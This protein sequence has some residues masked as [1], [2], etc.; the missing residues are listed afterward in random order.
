MRTIAAILLAGAACITTPLAAQSK[1]RDTTNSESAWNVEAPKG[2]V[3]KQVPIRTDEGTWI[4][5]DVSP[6]GRTL[7]FTLLGDIYTMPI[8]GGTPRRI[9]DGL[10]WDVQPRFSPDGSRIAF[11][12]DRGGGDNIWVMNTD[13]TDK[14][15]VTKENFRLLNQPTWSPD[16]R[17][18]AAKKHYTTE[19]SAG[20]GEI[21]LYHVSG[22]G[23]V[24]VVERANERLQK[25][26]GEPVFAPDGSAIYYTRNT[27]PGNVFEYAQDSNAGIFAIER[28][29]LAT[30]EVTTA[31][32]GYGGAVRPAPSP[33]GA[34]LAFVRRDKDQSQLWVKDIENGRERMIFGQLDLDV[35]ETW[36][37]TGVYPN[38]DWLPDSSGIVFWAGGK[39]NRVNRDGT[40]HAVIPFAINDTRG[41][42][43]APHP[44]IAVAPDTFV[45]SMPRFATLSPDS[46]RVVFES[47]GRLYSKSARG[48]DAPAPL[49]GDTADVVEAFPAF[50]R[51]GQNLAYVRWSDNALG[52]IVIADANGQNRRVLTGPGHFGNLAFSPDGSM[53]AF[54]KREGGYLTAADYSEN[55]GIYVISVNG[56]EA[57]LVSRDGSVPQWGES[58]SRLFMVAREGNGIALISTDLSGEAKRIHAKGEL[59]NDLRISPDGR[60]I[61]FRQN[62]EVFAMPVIPGGKPVDVSETGGALPVTK[63]SKGGADYLGWA[64][65]GET[66]FWSIGPSLQSA[67]V[68]ELFPAAPKADG[69]KAASYTP[70]ATGITLGVTVQAAKPAGTTV[71]TGARVLTMKAGLGTQDAGVIENGLI[72]ITGD[73]ITGV[74]DATT[75]RIRLPDDAVMIDASGKTI[76]PGLVDAHAHGAYGVG[77][78][79]PQQN[80]ALLQDLALGVTTV[81]NPSSQASTVF[82]AAERQRAGLTLGPR[83]FSTGEIIYGAKAPGVYA[84][85][86]T[87]EDALAHVRRIKAQGGISVKNYNQPRREQRQMVARAAAAENML[88]VAEGGSLFGMDMNLVADGNSTLEHNVPVDVFYEDVLQFFGQSNSNYTPTLV[89]TYGGLAG[90]PYWRQATNV[91]ENPLMVHTPPKMLLAETGRRTTAPD[92][93]FVDDNNARE[94]RKLAERGVKV[95]IGAHGQQA[96]IGAHWELW[97]FVRGGMTPVEALKAGTIT[98]AQSLGM[99]KDIGSIEVGKLADLVI[100]SDDPSADIS[101]SDNIEKVMLGGRLYDAVTMN[102]VSTGNAT[103]QPYWWEANGGNGAG[104]G[105]HTTESGRGHADGDAG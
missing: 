100:L 38:I 73:R 95:S 90:D 27:T 33:D 82:A 89:V 97:S 104:G 13:G 14:R 49:T 31:V 57:R 74:Y 28:H 63:V 83:I 12:S 101:N 8:E 35:Q 71:I 84:R 96:G 59:A 17:F 58:A 47:L 36:A 70:P 45:T 76:M 24:Q 69:A 2:A 39:L 25:E 5:V 42:A 23:G 53:I 52:D 60:T 44:D 1:G 78:L 46:T 67:N 15:Q 37:V 16:G 22:G 10:A 9:A 34:Q 68:A 4:D 85:I 65:G 81:H 61:A 41:I 72:V 91:W 54:E 3:I 19:R 103:R 77:D 56:G 21:W 92:W 62:Y 40:G 105:E 29:D 75:V 102:E 80:W 99:G 86:D 32:S 87:Y 51:D 88:V 26:L 79:I 50:S 6:D 94:A 11:T 98:S 43:D 7:A 66:L 20:T 55:P 48:R 30:G 93:A 64:N 18:I